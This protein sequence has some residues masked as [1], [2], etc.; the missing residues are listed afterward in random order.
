MRRGYECSLLFPVLKD[1]SA[2]SF[3]AQRIPQSMEMAENG[4]LS[5]AFKWSQQAAYCSIY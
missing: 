4:D 3:T 2:V 1:A 5:F